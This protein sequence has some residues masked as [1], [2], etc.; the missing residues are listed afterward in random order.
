MPFKPYPYPRCHLPHCRSPLSQIVPPRLEALRCIYGILFEAI[1]TRCDQ[2]ACGA[3]GPL[4]LD[5]HSRYGESV[6]CK[7]RNSWKLVPIV[8]VASSRFLRRSCTN[9]STSSKLVTPVDGSIA[10][11]GWTSYKR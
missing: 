5:C 1:S 2:V 11:R 3:K 6:Q 7:L 9:S 8:S 4:A 10:E